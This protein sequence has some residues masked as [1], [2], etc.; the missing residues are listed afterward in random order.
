MT[1]LYRYAAHSG[2]ARVK[3]DPAA[4]Q[5]ILQSME[6]YLSN[7]ISKS[8]SVTQ[9]GREVTVD[10]ERAYFHLKE[11]DRLTLYVP[12]KSSEREVCFASE[13]PEALL[14][15]L[16]ARITEVGQL[17]HIITASSISTFNM[18]LGCQGIIDVPGLE[19]PDDNSES[20]PDSSESDV[21]SLESRPVSS[22][23]AATLAHESTI[24]EE[25]G[26][27]LA[28]PVSV[29]FRARDLQLQVDH[30]KKLI[31]VL[32]WQ[33][34]A[35]SALPSFGRAIQTAAAIDC[36]LDISLALGSPDPWKRE[37][38]IDAA[39]ELFVCVCNGF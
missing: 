35:F 31:D 18:L 14:K 37:K 39:G 16:G 13:L 10:Q 23:G 25:Q 26:V 33:A 20:E 36:G 1:K 34:H 8:L 7:I 17:G 27:T 6:V 32:I 11:E 21:D 19:I 15:H 24:S 3:Q 38:N 4:V 2:S 29:A 12:K 5:S 22:E 30:Y 28:V 9:G